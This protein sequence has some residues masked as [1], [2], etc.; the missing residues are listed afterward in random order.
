MKCFMMRSNLQVLVACGY[1]FGFNTQETWRHGPYM[2]CFR[3]ARF[4][5]ALK[6]AG[7]HPRCS[8]QTCEDKC[9]KCQMSRHM[10]IEYPHQPRVY[11]LN[12]LVIFCIPSWINWVVVSNIFLFVAPLIEE[13]I[14]LD[15]F[16]PPFLTRSTLHLVNESWKCKELLRKVAKSEG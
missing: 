2:T 12:P 1:L 15:F 3:F 14:Q 9:L 13:I 7:A 4:F 5:S 10:K 11:K 6:M 8:R 16:F